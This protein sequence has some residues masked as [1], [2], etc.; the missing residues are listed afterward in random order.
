MAEISWDKAKKFD[1][2]HG[3]VF[4]ELNAAFEDR[5]GCCGHDAGLTGLLA[6]VEA[7]EKIRTDGLVRDLRILR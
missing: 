3:N 2:K 6:I 4:A 7:W 1:A 5:G